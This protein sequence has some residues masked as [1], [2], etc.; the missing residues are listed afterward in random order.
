MAVFLVI[1]LT[2]VAVMEL[3]DANQD[4]G[5]PPDPEGAV[6][7][8]ALIHDD[9]VSIFTAYANSVRL[10]NSRRVEFTTITGNRI[11][12]RGADVVISDKPIERPSAPL[13]EE[14]GYGDP[15]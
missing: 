15:I 8:V 11:K 12:S 7:Y 10:H 14:K 5:S 4:C 9:R 3:T 13:I 6:V 1:A 2:V